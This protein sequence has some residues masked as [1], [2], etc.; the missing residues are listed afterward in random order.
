MLEL[1]HQGWVWIILT[2]RCSSKD[3]EEVWPNHERWPSS[4]A[5]EA[6]EEASKAAAVAI[7]IKN[8]FEI[9]KMG[10]TSKF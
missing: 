2:A 3:H 4:A 8:R 6:L 9:L 7:K 1:L 5:D 10:F